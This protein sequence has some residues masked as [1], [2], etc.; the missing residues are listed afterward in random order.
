MPGEP[1]PRK[2][3]APVAW[4]LRH[5]RVARPVQV[6][7]NRAAIGRPARS[8]HEN[9]LVARLYLC[10]AQISGMPAGRCQVRGVTRV[11]RVYKHV[12]FEETGG[13]DTEGRQ[14]CGLELAAAVRA[15][16]ASAVPPQKASELPQP[17]SESH[18][19][20]SRGRPPPRRSPMALPQCGWATNCAGRHVRKAY[21]PRR[22]GSAVGAAPRLVV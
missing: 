21:G 13:L 10:D 14:R 20:S 3:T 18:S 7:G 12:Q 16:S 22:E 4:S 17:G 8:L 1:G 2:D 11:H 19:G 6:S 15:I 9:L 5:G